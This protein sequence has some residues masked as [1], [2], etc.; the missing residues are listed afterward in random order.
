MTAS[1]SLAKDFEQN[2]RSTV[3]GYLAFIKCVDDNE[4]LRTLEVLLSDDRFRLAIYRS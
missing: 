2:S 3:I 4:D 1:C